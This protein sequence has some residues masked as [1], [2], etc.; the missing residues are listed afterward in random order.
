MIAWLFAARSRNRTSGLRAR[1][2]RGGQWPPTQTKKPFGIEGQ[3]P[4]QHARRKGTPVNAKKQQNLRRLI[5]A[6]MLTTV[7]QPE[8]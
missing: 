3:L 4:P 1:G 7:Q 2:P 6:I 8:C 5:A